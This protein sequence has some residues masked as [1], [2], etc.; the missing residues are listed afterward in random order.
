MRQSLKHH[1]TFSLEASCKEFKAFDSL[2]QLVQL[3]EGLNPNDYIILGSGSNTVFVDD[4]SFAVFQNKI[5]GLSLDKRDDAYLLKVGAG[6]NWHEL[7]SWCVEQGING[8]ENL[9]LIPGT[10]GAA[11]I[12]NIGAYGVEVE[13]FI[14]SVEFYDTEIKCV[15]QFDHD[16]CELGYRDSIFK[17]QSQ[18][19]R[20]ITQVNFK[21]P[22]DYQIECSYS[23]LDKLEQPSAKDV[24]TRVIEVRQSKLPS[25]N[26]FGNAGSFFKNPIVDIKHLGRIQNN[27]PNIPTFK[28][29][30]EYHKVP[31]AWLI[32]SLG[33]KGQRL[34][35]VK[36]FEKQP[37]VLVNTGDGKGSE[38]VALAS[39]IKQ[40]V[41]DEF[42]IDL[43][44]EV[45]L[46]ARNEMLHL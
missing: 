45:R 15:G 16:E 26:E 8:F 32:D 31:A 7:V 30:D 19:K 21:I 35:G 46:L 12:Q 40:A 3:I 24:Y 39:K 9:A 1:H 42:G 20:I 4:V 2:A 23:P 18:N 41:Y 37:L 43:E 33:F 44:N 6:N 14:E 36:C 13:R 25:L 34:G 10:V 11:P 38:L 28:I 22:K 29:N 27:W 17:R 5:Q